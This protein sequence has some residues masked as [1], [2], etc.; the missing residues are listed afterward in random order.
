MQEEKQ[1]DF[2]TYSVIKS[3]KTQ[4][5]FNIEG[6]N[7]YKKAKKINKIMLYAGNYQIILGITRIIIFFALAI[8]LCNLIALI[9][10][11]QRKMQ[12]NDSTIILKIK[13]SGTIQILS[14]DFNILPYKILINGNEQGT[15]Q[16]AYGFTNSENTINTITLKWNVEITSTVNM[17]YN[18]YKII[19]IDCTSFDTS[20]VMNMSRMF[21]S[22]NGLTS[23]DISNFGTS[24]V[25]D[26]KQMFYG[27]SDLTS[28][29]VSSLDT[30]KVT[31]FCS[32]FESCNSL[33]S[34]NISN[35]K[36]SN[37]INMESMFASCYLLTSLNLSNLDT[38][39]VTTMNGMFFACKSLTEL[40]LSNFDTSNVSNM[41]HM[42]N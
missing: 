18:C 5:I 39:K 36:T 21:M 1:K 37:A 13:G 7:K 15:I 42:F 29:D 19:E 23:L 28:L 35:F 17:F 40:N 16:K 20:K 26:M 11:N 38:S 9:E 14:N 32:I 34:L 12:S 10:C 8:N 31:N 22:C 41:N 25:L 27:L 33:I 3:P 6:S 24:K 2:L 30:S 4:N